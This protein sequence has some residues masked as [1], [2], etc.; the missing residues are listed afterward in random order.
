MVDHTQLWRLVLV[1]NVH[2]SGDAS[3]RKHLGSRLGVSLGGV[4]PTCVPVASAVCVKV[5]SDPGCSCSLKGVESP[6]FLTAGSWPALGLRNGRQGWKDAP[7]P[8]GRL[9][10]KEG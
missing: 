8:R 9:G 4:M 6:S 10:G 1:S 5:P 7:P 3:A 2:G